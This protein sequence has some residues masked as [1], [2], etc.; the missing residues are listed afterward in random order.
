MPQVWAAHCVP[1]LVSNATD[2]GDACDSSS[3]SLRCANAAAGGASS[4]AAFAA[5]VGIK[6]RQLAASD[7]S[8]ANCGHLSTRSGQPGCSA[9]AKLAAST[10][11]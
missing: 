8:D 11:R 2:G 10:P 5:P 4:T 6:A 9:R 1:A 3:S 7:A